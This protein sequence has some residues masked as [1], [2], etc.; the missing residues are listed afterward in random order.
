VKEIH[1]LIGESIAN[2]VAAGS[3]WDLA[4]ETTTKVA[5]RVAEVTAVL[6]AIAHGL[7]GEQGCSGRPRRSPAPAHWRD[8]WVTQQERG[9]RGGRA[10]TAENFRLARALTSWWR[11][12]AACSRTDRANDAAGVCSRCVKEAEELWCGG[13]GIFV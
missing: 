1:G 2:V 10:A 7:R 3:S 13:H 11:G 5:A 4:G 6:G 9:A 12:W 8:H